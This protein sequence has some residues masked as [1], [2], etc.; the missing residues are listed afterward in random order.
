MDISIFELGFFVFIACAWPI[1]IVRML[2]KK[3]TKGKSIIFSFILLLGYVFGIGHKV[4]FRLDWV[5]AVYILNFCL[6]TADAIV[7]FYIR[8]KYEKPTAQKEAA[9]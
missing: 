8:S 4:L 3:S 6:I 1:S 5:L 2:R 7:F 9:S